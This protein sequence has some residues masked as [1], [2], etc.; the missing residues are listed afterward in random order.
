MTLRWTQTARDDLQSIWDYIARDS[1][2]YADKFIDELLSRPNIL[3]TFPEIGRVI[4]EICDPNSR[5]ITHGSYRIMYVIRENA[6]YITQI[7]HMAR[8][9]KPEDTDWD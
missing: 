9:F 6:I 4:P 1:V 5:E 8:D 3:K 7:A 2:Y